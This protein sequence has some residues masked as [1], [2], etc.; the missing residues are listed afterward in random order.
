MWMGPRSKVQRRNGSKVACVTAHLDP[1]PIPIPYACPQKTKDQKKKKKKT[2]LGISGGAAQ[3]YRTSKLETCMHACMWYTMVGPAKYH[4]TYSRTHVLVTR[5]VGTILNTDSV[6]LD[7][8]RI[9]GIKGTPQFCCFTFRQLAYLAHRP[10]IRSASP[11]HGHAT[12]CAHVGGG[13]RGRLCPYPLPPGPFTP[14]NTHGDFL[15]RTGPRLAPGFLRS[16]QGAG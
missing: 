5:S 12:K 13:C 7:R 8:I 9:K 11:V 14:A 1:I 4:T 3:N 16:C 15:V 6:Q 2:A 10:V